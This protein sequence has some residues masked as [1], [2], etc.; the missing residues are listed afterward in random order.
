MCG[1]GGLNNN[2]PTLNPLNFL[3]TKHINVLYACRKMRISIISIVNDVAK[4]VKF[5]HFY[6]FLGIFSSASNE[7]HKIFVTLQKN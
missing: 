5:F 2:I 3:E 7:I 4:V 6:K 1:A